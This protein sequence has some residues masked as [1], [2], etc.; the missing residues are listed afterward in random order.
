MWYNGIM[1]KTKT[2]VT[3]CLAGVISFVSAI[4]S[5][6]FLPNI[7][8][9]ECTS[10]PCDTTFEIDVKEILTVS[11]TS[12]TVYAEGGVN[13]L[14]TE[15]VGVSVTSNNASGFVAGI[16]ASNS[17]ATLVDN[18]GGTLANLSSATSAS[19]FPAGKWGYSLDTSTYNPVP[20]YNVTPTVFLSNNTAGTKSTNINF[21]AKAGYGNQSGL[22]TGTVNI[23]V[24]SGSNSPDPGPTPVTPDTPPA[25]PT[26]HSSQGVTTYTTISNN[27]SAGTTTTTT[28]ISSGNNTAK[29]T[30]P[31]GETQTTDAQSK[32]KSSLPVILAVTSAVSA[33]AGLGFFIIAKRRE[34]EDEEDEEV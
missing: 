9:A 15:Q 25:T 17:E 3:I 13:K 19:S 22:Y 20:A 23:S 4:L 27:S 7:S 18:H 30:P 28:E 14:L 2:K 32:N 29:Y 24:V 5:C 21:A 34:E 11:I 12:P 6:L 10:S 33:A 1:L 31:Q 8:A 26:Y 16:R